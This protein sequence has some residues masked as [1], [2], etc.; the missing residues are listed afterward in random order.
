MGIYNTINNKKS[1]KSSLPKS[2]G[3]KEE[4]TQDLLKATEKESKFQ[5]PKDK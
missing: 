1:D 3:I 4:M 5:E 2:L